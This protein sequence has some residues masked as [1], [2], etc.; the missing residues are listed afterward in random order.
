M[1][2]CVGVS[3]SDKVDWSDTKPYFQSF[4]SLQHWGCQHSLVQML[5]G[6]PLP[7][8]HFPTLCRKIVRAI[9]PS[10]VVNALM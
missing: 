8:T 9:D 7:N 6:L 4:S 3:Q 10:A 5:F 1:F 2:G